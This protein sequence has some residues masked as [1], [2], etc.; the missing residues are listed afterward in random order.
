MSVNDFL[1]EAEIALSGGDMNGH[2]ASDYSTAAEN[3][4]DSFQFF[5]ICF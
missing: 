2:S 4:I 1:A 5:D 3:I